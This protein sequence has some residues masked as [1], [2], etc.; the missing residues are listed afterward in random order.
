MIA[1]IVDELNGFETMKKDLCLYGLIN[2]RLSAV[3]T[4]FVA[5][6]MAR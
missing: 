5:A 1:V 6:M 2:G 3:E 4:E